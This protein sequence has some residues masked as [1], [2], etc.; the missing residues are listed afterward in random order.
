MP[1][2]HQL[3]H[4]DV[5]K[6]MRLVEILHRSRLE[7]IRIEAEAMEITIAKGDARPEVRIAS[8]PASALTIPAPNVGVFRADGVRVGSLVEEA[9]ALGTIQTLDEMN[10]VTAGLAGKII[11]GCV[12]D[13]DFVE[14]G[15]PLYRILPEGRSK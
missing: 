3:T 6:I 9:T 12:R 1:F 13:G 4:A 10:T 8:F 11:E 14:F 15:Q 2:V 7:F 5:E